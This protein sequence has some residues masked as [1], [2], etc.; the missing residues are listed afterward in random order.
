VE[1]INKLRENSYSL[2]AHEYKNEELSQYYSANLI[3]LYI[4]RRN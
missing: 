3:N 1:I 2:L 4:E